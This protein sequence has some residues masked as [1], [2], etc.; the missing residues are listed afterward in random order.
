[1]DFDFQPDS[2]A[3]K[4]DFQPD[5]EGGVINGLEGFFKKHGMMDQDETL[6]GDVKGA[7]ETIMSLG[8]GAAALPLAIAPAA[9]NS[10]SEISQGRKPH[11]LDDYERYSG[12]LQYQPKTDAGKQNVDEAGDVINRYLVPLAGLTHV[13]N[14]ALEESQL[15]IDKAKEKTLVEKM[16][17]AENAAKAGTKAKKFDFQ[18]ETQQ[19]LFTQ[20]NQGRTP[21]PF[22]AQLGKWTTD[23]NGIPIRQDLSEDVQATT[24]PDAYNRP[25]EAPPV[26]EGSTTELPTQTA[27]EAAQLEAQRQAQLGAVR[28]QLGSFDDQVAQ[29]RKAESAAQAQALIEARQRALEES[30]KRQG[31]LDFNA[32]ERARQEQQPNEPPIRDP[33]DYEYGIQEPGNTAVS[34]TLADAG[35]HNVEPGPRNLVGRFLKDESGHLDIQPI[36]E[37]IKRL[38]AGTRIMLHDGRVGRVVGDRFITFTNPE[39]LSERFREENRKL[40]SR[41]GPENGWS[42]SAKAAR[43]AAYQRVKEELAGEKVG[44]FIPRVD[45]GDG[46]A[47]PVFPSDIKNTINGP[48]AVF[49]QSRPIGSGPGGKQRGAILVRARAREQMEK[50]LGKQDMIPDDPKTADVLEAAREEKDGKGF[51]Y[52]ENGS[53][54]KAMKTGSSAIQAVSEYVQNATKRAELWINRNVHPAEQAFRGLSRAEFKSI[55]DVLKAEMLQ[56]KRWSAQALSALSTKQLTA[57]NKLRTMF[58]ESL[59]KQNE[60]RAMRGQEPITEL[61]AYMSSRWVG[62]F[63]R[64]VYEA[65]L[66]RNGNPKFDDK[67]NIQKK[68]VWYLAADTK[69]GLNRQTKALLK[70]RPDLYFDK[71]LDH[72]VRSF[73]NQPEMQSAYTTMIDLLGRDDPAVAKIKS[74]M[75]DIT[76]NEAASFLFQEKHFEPKAGVHGFVGDRPGKVGSMSE[77]LDFIQQQMQYARNAANWSEMQKAADNI[78]E[79]LNDPTLRENQPNNINYIREYTKNALGHGEAGWAAMLSDALRKGTGV[80]PA[81]FGR[82]LGGAKSLFV[83]K[84]LVMSAGFTIANLAQ[85]L[86]I[87]PHLVNEFTANG[88]MGNPLTAIPVGLAGGVAMALGH[89]AKYIMDIKGIDQDRAGFYNRAVKYAEDNGI[90]SRSIYDEAPISTSFNPLQQGVRALSRTVSAPE[91]I[92][93]SVAFM[94]A[95]EFLRSSKTFKTDIELFRRAEELTN[96]SMVDYRSTERPMMFSKLGGIGNFLNTLQTFPMNF[97]NQLSFFGKEAVKGNALPFAS[98][99]ALTYALGGIQAVPYMQDLDR[100]YQFIKNHLPTVSYEKIRN[101]EFWNDPKMWMVTHLGSPSVYGMLADKTGLN[102]SSRVAAP[103][104]LDMV[105]APGGPGIELGKDAYQLGKLALDP[106]NKDKQAQAAMSLSPAGLQGLAETAPYFHGQTFENRVDPKTGQKVGTIAMRP[107]D[108]EDHKAVYVR[109]QANVLGKLRDEQQVRKYGFGLRSQAEAEGREMNYRID[110]QNSN[111]RRVAQD[112]PNEIYA[113]IKQGDMNHVRELATAYARLTGKGDLNQQLATQVE[114]NFM[115]NF[116]REAEKGSSLPVTALKNLAMAKKIMDQIDK[117]YRQK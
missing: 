62:D 58:K 39:K 79:I 28:D 68:L 47:R 27:G 80:S 2:T 15:P 37:G 114:Q 97:Y 23:E 43:D 88:R 90:T 3:K 48:K 84:Q 51:T 49:D 89:W 50:V 91:T 32:E 13:N 1:M 24:S 36:V 38:A 18:P 45:F 54:L 81:M 57:Y 94:T 25:T 71:K 70:E 87:L 95:V 10:L 109:T 106:T 112:I 34:Q 69:F 74:Y 17:E 44:Q 85:P 53:T 5:E 113:S 92:A 8:S 111:D 12:Q 16:Q 11:F 103:G 19:D 76:K 104:M 82:M 21:N 46:K 116:E 60:V 115:T 77:S 86:F 67:G 99:F 98:F 59:D 63:R 56:N 20:D 30:V 52:T 55:A 100:V 78:K 65:I 117:E 22:E 14:G 108:I 101:D 72:T 105:Q 35:P 40:S 6:G 29:Q 4:F 64:P 9:L 66:D 26:P 41:Y 83:M 102:V 61:E 96:A 73:R 110:Q 7:F 33:R 42:E 107:A 31:T 75:D 93:R